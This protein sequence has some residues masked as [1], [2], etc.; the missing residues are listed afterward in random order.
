MKLFSVKR[1]TPEWDYMWQELAKHPINKGIKEPT[2]SYNDGELWEYMGSYVF[3]KKNSIHEFRHRCHPKT[4]EREYIK[5]TS[6]K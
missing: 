2:V 5:I 6:K 4:E 3:D 1:D